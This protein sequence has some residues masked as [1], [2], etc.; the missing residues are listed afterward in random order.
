MII[1]HGD[2]K[3]LRL[4]PKVAKYQVVI[5]PIYRKNNNDLINDYVN[6][7]KSKVGGLGVRVHVDLRNHNPGWKYN[8]WEM[9]GIPVRLHVGDRDVNNHT[10]EVFRRDL[11][12]KSQVSL[13]D[14]DIISLLQD[15]HDTLYQQALAK[16]NESMISGSTMDDYLT[17]IKHNK[18]ILLPFCGNKD[19]EASLSVGKSSC[20]PFDQPNLDHSCFICGGIAKFW[21]WFGMSY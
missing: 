4:P 16:Q 13:N 11:N 15:I 17:A 7:I 3:G 21:T 14:L 6:Q 10:V 18:K 20:V 12:T 19:C 2:N 8:D 1:V 5:I 9:Q